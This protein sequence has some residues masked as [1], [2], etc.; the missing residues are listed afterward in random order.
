MLK[1]QS[2]HSENWMTNETETKIIFS[3][4]YFLCDAVIKSQAEVARALGTKVT[5][6]HAR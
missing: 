4:I 6:T 3:S 5:Y 1:I 2:S